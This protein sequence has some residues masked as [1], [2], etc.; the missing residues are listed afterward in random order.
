MP[1]IA[2]AV[3]SFLLYDA[4]FVEP[5]FTLHVD[6]PEE[7]LN[8]LLL[9][10]VGIV[11]GRL[12]ALQAERADDATRRA[13]ESRA[14]FRISRTLATATSVTDA[15]PVIVEDLLAETRMERIW[16]ARSDAGREVVVADS[17]HGPLPSHRIH[18]SLTRTPGDLPARWVQEH[19]P[20]DRPGAGPPEPGV[21]LYRIVIA[22]GDEPVGSIWATR[23]ARRASPMARRPGS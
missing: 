23:S 20:Q 4:L 2:A 15:L 5:R 12:A 13:A 21:G 14:L 16:L 6:D 8:L 18:V 22:A 11:I 7:W 1:S 10:F 3:A 17:G 9:L 19:R